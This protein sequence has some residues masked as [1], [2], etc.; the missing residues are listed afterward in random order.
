MD[1]W[2]APHHIPLW[3]ALVLTTSCTATTRPA[4]GTKHASLPPAPGVVRYRL[5][6]GED[7]PVDPHEA[8]V[9]FSACQATRTESEY[10]KCLSACPGAEVTAGFECDPADGTPRSACVTERPPAPPGPPPETVAAAVVLILTPI[11]LIGALCKPYGYVGANGSYVS[12][13]WSGAAGN[14]YWRLRGY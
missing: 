6:L 2:R 5:T 13:C 11:L 1:A 3:A 4:G 9:C 14:P 12:P 10:A 8:L 7:N